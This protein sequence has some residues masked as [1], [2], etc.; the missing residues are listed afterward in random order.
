MLHYYLFPIFLL[1]I[2]FS[3]QTALAG[4]DV[5][6]RRDAVQTTSLPPTSTSTITVKSGVADGAVRGTATHALL[7]R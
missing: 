2:D 7:V 5:Q 1:H 6:S 4:S 3:L